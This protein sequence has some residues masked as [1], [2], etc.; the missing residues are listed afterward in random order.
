MLS[1]THRSEDGDD[2]FIAHG[3]YWQNNR[4]MA[5]LRF[6][7]PLRTESF[8]LYKVTGSNYFRIYNNGQGSHQIDDIGGLNSQ[9]SV[10]SAHLNI[11]DATSSGAAGMF[12][13]NNSAARLGFDAE[14]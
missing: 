10:S 3:F 2:A 7:V 9:A 11:T 14:L 13:C 5:P 6:D 12:F 4:F 8:S 1:Q